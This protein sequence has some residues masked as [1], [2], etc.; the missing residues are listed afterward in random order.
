[1]ERE[2]IYS[3]LEDTTEKILKK[4]VSRRGFLK[5]VAALAPVP[6]IGFG[7]EEISVP[8]A[9]T[10]APSPSEPINPFLQEDDH[11]ET[12]HHSSL[13]NDL[14][15][16]GM[17]AAFASLVSAVAAE[18][19]SF[20]RET[21]ATMTGLGIAR[22]AALYAKDREGFHHEI[23]EH[24]GK[25]SMP[26]GYPLLPVL[27]GLA[28][29]AAH[30]RAEND[31]IFKSKDVAE[32]LA[33][34]LG[35][36]GQ[37]FD[38][39]PEEGDSK[40][41]WAN[42]YRSV[43]NSVI[44]AAARNAALTSVLAPLG[45]TY[46]SAAIANENFKKMLPLLEEAQYAKKIVNTKEEREKIGNPTIYP[47]EIEKWQA[48]AKD[49]ALK[50]INGKDGYVHLNIALST[51][52]NGALLIGDPPLIYF[53][54]R[55]PKLYAE[56]SIYGLAASVIATLAENYIWITRSL[57]HE[58]AQRFITRFFG[59][60]FT[61]LT[62]LKRSFTNGDLRDVSFGGAKRVSERF[63][64]KV[65]DL[66]E[67]GALTED[68]AEQLRSQLQDVEQP[69]F[70]FDI[71]TLIG[72][73]MDMLSSFIKN[74]GRDKQER[75]DFVD[76]ED[77]GYF[78]YREFEALL[79]SER[80]I[81]AFN[82]PEPQTRMD[83]IR[84]LRKTLKEEKN[85]EAVA[86]IGSLLTED[87][88]NV[89]DT[90][91]VVSRILNLPLSKT[92]LTVGAVQAEIAKRM[93]DIEDAHITKYLQGRLEQILDDAP[94]V[95]SHEIKLRLSLA[96]EY[97]EQ[98]SGNGYATQVKSQIDEIIDNFDS[99][100]KDELVAEITEVLQTSKQ[101]YTSRKDA[102]YKKEMGELYNTLSALLPSD[103]KM[104]MENA[105][106]LTENEEEE[107]PEKH[108]LEHQAKEVRDVLFTQLPAVPSLIHTVNKIL[109]KAV[110][111]G[112]DGPNAEQLQQMTWAI[113]GSTAITSAFADNVAAYLFGENVLDKL[114]SDYYGDNYS[115]ELKK[116]VYIAALLTAVVAGSLS[117]IGNGPNVTLS[118][119]GPEGED[120]PLTL[121]STLGNPYAIVQTVAL[122][123]LLNFN[124]ERNKPED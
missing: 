11:T 44:T 51:N 12:E 78:G 17:T 9:S 121:G 31:E 48:E 61:T 36:V 5:G 54:L 123:S 80:F 42:Y 49:K 22:A 63:M 52:L 58:D 96:R 75:K 30:V 114:Y 95:S 24:L 106:R 37:L 109:P 118:R 56:A 77:Y 20:N 90:E 43:K 104:A 94:T 18:K 112:E 74:F 60:Q 28:E 45:T 55:H 70:Y 122:T 93:P 40:E 111:V 92:K 73:K 6:V 19:A 41:E 35:D 57:G 99:K 103:I 98:V 4:P 69:M 47:D 65:E 64:D 59:G 113:L 79:E 71:P 39:R 110:G 119:I 67:T 27:V 7:H 84:S 68:A 46:T 50:N 100:S 85:N 25:P 33:S 102:D 116:S 120:I 91:T 82:S 29:G 97:A 26:G 21:A 10:E 107:H 32:T 81:T 1:M 105:F 2:S 16:Y 38:K 13:V 66:R 14:S 88:N 15:A 83:V 89:P 101:L 62:A 87:P 23:T 117:K 124:I 3:N 34:E 115:D 8:L 86:L 53:A 76:I 108:F 72:K